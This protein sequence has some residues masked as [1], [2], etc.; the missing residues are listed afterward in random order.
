MKKIILYIFMFT[1]CLFANNY[2]DMFNEL[3]VVT[4]FIILDGQTKNTIEGARV[5]INDSSNFS[6]NKGI[7]EY[8]PSEGEILEEEIVN[9]IITKIGYTKYKGKLKIGENKKRIYLDRDE[10]NKI[11]EVKKINEDKVVKIN[12]HKKILT[13][14]VRV[15]ALEDGILYLSDKKLRNI[16]SSRESFFRIKEGNRVLTLDTEKA[17]YRKN[18][19]VI[20]PEMLVVFNKGDIIK[21]KEIKK[22]IL[23]VKKIKPVVE[24]PIA[25]PVK[26]S[27]I[28]KEITNDYLI[29]EIVKPLEDGSAFQIT[30]KV[31]Y[32]EMEEDEDKG[33][34]VKYKSSNGEVG[35]L[36]SEFVDSLRREISPNELLDDYYYIRSNTYI[37]LKKNY[38]ERV[39]KIMDELAVEDRKYVTLNSNWNE[40]RDNKYIAICNKNKV[41]N[42]LMNNLYRMSYKNTKKYNDFFSKLDKAIHG[43]LEYQVKLSDE[44]SPVFAFNLVEGGNYYSGI[45][46]T[47]GRPQYMDREYLKKL[48][49][50][51]YSG[52]DLFGIAI[53]KDNVY[54]FFDNTVANIEISFLRKNV[55]GKIIKSDY[56]LVR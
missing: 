16:R 31:S 48:N 20:A 12:K 35:K 56:K 17:I 37:K 10:K 54:Y 39:K 53:D 51:K 55:E 45:S 3:E 22:T 28:V 2:D 6:D 43:R 21:I 18:I 27:K 40:E 44:S 36:D 50:N 11:L 5:E 26:T 32:F 49:Y 42:N 25:N 24:K 4:S 15:L 33:N 19:N 23:P 34:F 29:S 14:K 9:F 1:T 7:V 46:S 38:V 8:K 13:S 41:E 30:T 47:K 52:T